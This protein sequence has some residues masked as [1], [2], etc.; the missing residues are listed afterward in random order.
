MLERN[1][2]WRFLS[3]SKNVCA[4][5]ISWF[6]I[7]TII[8][9]QSNSEYYSNMMFLIFLKYFPGNYSCLVAKFHLHRSIGFHLIQSYLPS[10]LIV[11]IS[12]VSFW[13]DVDCVPARVTLGVITLL[14]VSSQVSGRK[15]VS[16]FVKNSQ[17]HWNY[18]NVEQKWFFSQIIK[19]SQMQSYL[20]LHKLPSLKAKR[21]VASNHFLFC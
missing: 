1:F 11:S 16:K 3:K 18:W 10:I 17:M 6:S 14:T 8:N 15:N 19:Y 7:K 21:A 4:N 20:A 12:W 13:M 5:A 2:R 9:A